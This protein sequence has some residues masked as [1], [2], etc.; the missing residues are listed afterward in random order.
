[1]RPIF[2]LALAVLTLQAAALVSAQEERFPD[3]GSELFYWTCYKTCHFLNNPL[4]SRQGERGALPIPAKSAIPG[5]DLRGVFGAPA[6]RRAAEGY[7]HS[8]PFLLAAP[9]IIWTEA[10]LDKW[11]ESP[12]DVIRGT[13]MYVRVKDPQERREIIAYLKNYK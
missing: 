5:P 13:W 11:L 9:N 4:Q 1:M 10:M 7:R 2:P 8:E 6:G 12:Q 3:R